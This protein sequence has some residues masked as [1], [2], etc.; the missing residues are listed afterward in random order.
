MSRAD[1][2]YLPTYTISQ[3]AGEHVHTV[4]TGDAGDELFA[5]YNKYL[6]GHYSSIYK[7]VPAFIRNGVI[8]PV[9]SMLPANLKAV[10]KI[11]KVIDNS[12]LDA[13]SQRRNM[14][15]LGVRYEDVNKLLTYDGSTSLDF[16]KNV[17][18]KYEECACETD[19]TLYTD[20]KVVLE[21]DMLVKSDRTSELAGIVSIAPILHPDMIDL[22]AKIPVEY[23]IKEKDRKIILKDTF[24]DM[25]PDKI[26]KAKKTGFA[27][28]ISYWFQNELKADLTDTLNRSYI[29]KQGLFNPDYVEWLINEHISGRKNNSGILWA[30][31]VFEKW[32]HK[33]LEN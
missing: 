20:F 5:G 4:F 1:S 26:A 32:Y 28:P 16:I 23:K 3:I 11:N 15:C 21:G 13:Y 14:M 7:K 10:R 30:L 6:I 17:Y 8:K 22:A 25:I 19:R 31:Y 29:E 24:S 12:F 33:Y 2:S 18:D 27:V 9:V